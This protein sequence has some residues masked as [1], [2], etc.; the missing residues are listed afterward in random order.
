MI[1]LIGFAVGYVLGARAGQEGL[2]RVI[3]AAQSIARSEE[4]RGLLEGGASM[5]NSAVRQGTGAMTGD[6]HPGRQLGPKVA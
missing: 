2:G 6:G 1:G 5:L 4:L 3:N